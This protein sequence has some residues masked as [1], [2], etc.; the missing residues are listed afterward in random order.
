MKNLTSPYFYDRSKLPVLRHTEIA[1]R[2]NLCRIYP[3]RYMPLYPPAQAVAVNATLKDGL[4]GLDRVAAL[5]KLALVFAGLNSLHPF[6]EGNGRAMLGGGLFPT[7][8][9]SVS[10]IQSVSVS[11]GPSRALYAG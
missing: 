10:H 4:V 6:R 8:T 2:R 7:P 11:Q 5:N 9:R 3:T 1:L